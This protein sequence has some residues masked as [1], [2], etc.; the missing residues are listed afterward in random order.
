V[1]TEVRSSAAAWHT[2]DEGLD[3]GGAAAAEVAAGV[4]A[5]GV[6]LGDGLGGGVLLELQAATSSPAA[7]LTAMIVHRED[8]VAIVL[9]PPASTGRPDPRSVALYG[10]QH[11]TLP[12]VVLGQPARRFPGVP[13]G[14]GPGRRAREMFRLPVVTAQRAVRFTGD[15]R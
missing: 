9:P 4:V 12:G 1:S 14:T 6:G 10:R 15:I 11:I 7:A 13:I 2:A 3:V 8:P 5:A